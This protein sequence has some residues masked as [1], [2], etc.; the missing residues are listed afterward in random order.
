[1]T[2]EIQK[3]ASI[4][5]SIALISSPSA[6]KLTPAQ[7]WHNGCNVRSAIKYEPQLTHVALMT[8][9]KDAVDYLDYNKT[10]TSTKDFIDAVD[11]LVEWFPVMKV[12]EW[13]V[14]MQRLKAGHYGNRYERL[15]LPELVEI[16]KQYE[17]ER[18]EMRERDLQRQKD[19]PPTPLTEEQKH[20][21]KRLMKE[22]DLPEDDTDERGRWKWIEHPNSEIDDSSGDNQSN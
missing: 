14:I 20:I 5:Q 19:E 12:E 22:L 11:Y 1:M 9:L 17:G 4:A 21:F 3:K 18:A 2:K 6:N 8:L 16:F 15:K 7:A 10:I 13:K